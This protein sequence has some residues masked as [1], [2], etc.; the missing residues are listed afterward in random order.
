[1]LTAGLGS[2]WY[3]RVSKE[4]NRYGTT[5]IDGIMG[6]TGETCAKLGGSDRSK[7]DLL[8]YGAT[9]VEAVKNKRNDLLGAAVSAI[10]SP[11]SSFA[12]EGQSLTCK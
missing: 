1:M 5:T 3:I 10:V 4:I 6:V 7:D 9:Q 11:R 8:N 12:S 2:P